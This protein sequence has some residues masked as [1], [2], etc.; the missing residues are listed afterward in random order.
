[1]ELKQLGWSSFFEHQ[2]AQY[3][4]TDLVPARVTEE[5]KG[6]LR[7]RSALGESLAETRGK[8]HYQAENRADLPA[9]GD[10]VMIT[11][12]EAGR[13]RIQSIL[14]RR[15]KLSRKI[16]GRQ[17][18]EQILA[19]NLDTVFVVTS[20]N[21][22]FSPRRLERYLALVSDSGARSV[23]LLNKA[24][25]C[26][27]PSP[28]L[29]EIN[30]VALGTPVHVLSALEELG[31][32]TLHQYLAPGETA[33]FVGS[34][35]VGKSTIINALVGLDCLPVQPIREGDDRGRH[36]TT[37]RQMLFLRDRGIVIDTPGMRELQL[38]DNQQGVRHAFPDI[39]QLAQACKF[40]D[41][42][43]GGEPGCAVEDAVLNGV[44]DRD[45]LANHHKLL[46]ELHYQERKLDPVAAR[47]EKQKWKKIHKAMRHNAKA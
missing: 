23:I 34:S 39:A 31:L 16:A 20:F 43:H 29:D 37:S 46:A 25:L 13:A 11:N 2:L 41:C 19:T 35:G 21:R 3:C 5:L 15:S 44:L 12:R 36:T 1:M 47:K 24:D 26:L 30:Q 10:W 40:R 14:R 45:R 28:Y 8:V 6:F 9:V 18:R 33:T 32:E 4:H 27:D 17:P 22:D 42:R 38:L 7:V